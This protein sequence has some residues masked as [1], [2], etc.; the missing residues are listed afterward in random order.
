MAR[1]RIPIEEL[2]LRHRAIDEEQLQYARDHQ[3]KVGGDLGALLVDLGFVGEEVMLRAQAQQLG[4][5]MVNPE[6][7]PP[8][9][10][11]AAAL[12]E[13][14]C[15]R[16]GVIPVSGNLESKLLRVA[17]SSP[18]NPE[19][20]AMI[21][22]LSGFRVEP[23]AA[24]KDSI[25]KAIRIAFGAPPE[26]PLPEVLPEPEPDD[27]RDRVARLEKMLSNPQFAGLVA[28]VERLE[29]IAEKDHHALNV[30]C[31]VLLDLGFITREE[32]KKRLGSG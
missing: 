7:T 9:R 16:Y 5:P 26:E 27:L 2:L 31:Q 6:Q 18:S 23:A 12:T 14:L 10:E 11:L 19:R 32:L 13:A 15:K 24:T 29:Q 21:G 25:A 3:K 1:A 8:P 17:T 4:I 30:L 22:Q 20:L 28:R